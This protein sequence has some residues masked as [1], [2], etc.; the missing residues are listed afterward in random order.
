MQILEKIPQ[1]AVHAP[2][3]SCLYVRISEFKDT[4][5]SLLLLLNIHSC[6][7]TLRKSITVNDLLDSRCHSVSSGLVFENE[8]KL[9]EGL[10]CSLWEEEEDKDHFKSKPT[11]VGNKVAPGGVLNSLRLS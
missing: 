11:A 2:P 7:L 8:R 4:G 6:R 3:V 5:L 10:V 1:F 9:L